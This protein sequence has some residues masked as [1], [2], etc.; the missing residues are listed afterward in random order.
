M[1]LS[2][3]WPNKQP[4]TKDT[5]QI[6]NILENTTFPQDTILVTID[7]KSL[8]T[9]IPQDEGTRACLR[10]IEKSNQNH[11]PPDILNYLFQI[12]LKGNIF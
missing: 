4:P 1:T 6:I 7:V 8:Y 9:H 12:V 2:N 3:P 10:A 11:L 5:T